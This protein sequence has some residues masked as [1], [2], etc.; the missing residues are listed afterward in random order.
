MQHPF[1]LAVI[2]L[3][4]AWMWGINRGTAVAA[5]TYKRRQ[6]SSPADVVPIQL[7][8]ITTND[9]HSKSGGYSRLTS[10]IGRIKADRA[11]AATPSIVLTLD[12]GDW[13]SGTIFSALGSA[14]ELEYFAAAGYDAVALGNHDFDAGVDALKRMLTKIKA[15]PS[16]SPSPSTPSSPAVLSANLNEVLP[17]V[18]PYTVKEYSTATA[19]VR[20]GIFGLLSP[21]AAFA[22]RAN[23]RGQAT[24]TGYDDVTEARNPEAIF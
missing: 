24:F 18:A 22:S 19:T 20:I 8:V 15:S 1:V 23:R 9:M 12:A 7:T 3:G 6:P 14:P 2:V 11:D 4:F 13:Y 5:D 10:T 16:P 21:D 17:G